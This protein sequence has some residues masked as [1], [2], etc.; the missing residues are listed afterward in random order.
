[1]TL[2]ERPQVRNGRWCQTE[3]AFVDALAAALARDSHVSAIGRE[4]RSHGRCR[5][6]IGLRYDLN[7]Q[8]IILGVEAK[9]TD[10]GRA[11][12]QASLNR[13]AVHGSFIALPSDRVS[14]AMTAQAR[15]HGI[16]ILTL[17]SQRQVRVVAPAELGAPDPHLVVR[18]DQQLSASSRRLR[19]YT[20][21]FLLSDVI[22]AVS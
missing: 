8:S 18:L 16:G 5:T 1:M 2:T 22:G 9:L 15:D 3:Q 6:D 17:D 12:R 19:R 13:Y 4:V 10:W 11:I 14:G 20:E 7:D 21:L